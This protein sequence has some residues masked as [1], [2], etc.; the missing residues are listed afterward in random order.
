MIC[1]KLDVDVEARPI[2]QRK[3]NYSSE[4]NKSIAEEVKKLQEAGFIE[5]CMYPKWLANVVMVKKAN[6]YVDDSIV[7]SIKE[8][9][10]I[11]DLAETFGNLRKYKMKLNPKKCVFGVKSAKFLG[12][13]VSERGIDA[14][15]DK[16]Q[17]ALDL[18]EPETKRDKGR[19]V[20]VYVD[21][22]I[23][24]SIK[25][26]DHIKD[27]AETFDNLRKYKMKLN[28]KRCVFGVKSAKFMGFMVSERGIHANPDKVH[29][30]LDLPESETKRDVQRLTSSSTLIDLNT[31][32]HVEV[33]QE[34][35]IDLPPPTVC[36]LRPE[37]SWMDAIIAYKEK[38]EL[39]EDKLQA[40]KLKRFNRWFIIYAHGELMR[41]SFSSPLL[42]CVG[43]TDADYILR[44]VH[45][46]ICGNHIGGRSVAHKALR[47]GYS[48]PTMVS[49]AKT[50]T[51]KCEKCQKFASAIHQPAQTLQSILYPLPFSKWGLD[52]IGPFPSA[53]NQKKWLIVRVDY[54]SIYIEAEAVSAITETQVRKIIWQNI[55]TR[56]DI[57][58][59][60]VFDHGKQFDN[61]PLQ[62]W[63]KQFGI[64]LAYSAVCHPQ[65]NGKA[66][67]ANKLILNALKKRVEDEK[68]K[69][70]EEFP[71]TLWSLRTTEKEAI[72]RTP[73]NLVY[74]AEA[75]I[76]VSK[77]KA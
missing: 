71:G 57:P 18:P 61:T 59:L 75:V 29:E 56:F 65:R 15:P 3:M 42:K 74:G 19:N 4:K 16:V 70:L 5:P 34:R 49:E 66:E 60:M 35:S 36:N 45:L 48:W 54:F 52:I 53:V 8:E 31:S 22:S 25:E 11:K 21:D 13:M 14:N 27:L 9:D 28:P 30:A 10:H 73:F 24:K 38:G 47:A 46:G 69:W 63:C 7:K 20:E 32:V 39:P 67:A 17:E 72:G 64:H 43:P 50:M 44:E 40:R 37:P 55:I 2:K 33:Y 12:F 58:R 77:Q 62:N 23:V 51:R 76:P 68:S 1:H 41:K 26:E 6:E